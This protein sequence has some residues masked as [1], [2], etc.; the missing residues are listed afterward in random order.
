MPGAR[1]ALAGAVRAADDQEATAPYNELVAGSTGSTP[2]FQAEYVYPEALPERSRHRWQVG[3]H[4]FRADF[5]SANLADIR[6]T[7]YP[8][9]YQAWI[10]RDCQ[11]TPVE[12]PHRTWF[13]F[14]VAGVKKGE[15]VTITMM[16]MN[17][18][19]K[20][21]AQD[22]R[23]VYR[24]HPS[25]QIWQRLRTRVVA[26]LVGEDLTVQLSHCFE[27]CEETFFAFATPWSCSDNQALLDRLEGR[28]ASTSG[29]IGQAQPIYKKR[30]LLQRSL[31]GRPIDL[32]TITDNQG[33]STH[34]A[35][36]APADVAGLFPEAESEGDCRTFPGRQVFFISARVHPGETPASHMLNGMLEF[37]L[38][39]HDPRAIALR[40]LYVFKIVPMLNP[41]GVARG[42]TR[43]DSRGQNL[44]RCYR[45]P[46]Q[47]EQPGIWAV[48]QLLSWYASHGQLAFYMDLHAHA[49]KRGCF[50]YGN[51]MEGAAAVEALTFVKLA[52]LNCPHFDFGACNFTEQN[53]SSRDKQGESKDGTGRVALFRETSLTHL[54]TVEAN[55]NSSRLQNSV[56]A[57]T[58]SGKEQV[59]PPSKLRQSAFYSMDSFWGMGRALLVAALDLSGTNSCSRLANTMFQDTD[60]V[61]SWV[62][63][64]VKEMVGRKH[65]AV[66][67]LSQTTSEGISELPNGMVTRMAALR[68]AAT[69][70]QGRWR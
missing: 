54:Y 35:P 24:A 28:L 67:A 69:C 33:A 2:S 22:F 37:L 39:P 19:A 14:S 30:Q 36:A 48:K 55:Y 31:D 53:M 12:T 47:A 5:D 51:A 52:A 58:T 63:S 3:E 41:D 32:L 11:G 7:A 21:Y 64:C 38:R 56:A 49:N 44:N 25:M 8:N 29:H 65:A 43:C 40:R 62:R 17:K 34:P 15:P 4:S 27:S 61:A 60:G 10:C 45:A 18:Q 57:A 9:E 59:S 42:Y 26:K 20:L 46:S 50:A 1:R 13:H 16:N 6:A 68:L 23:P 66:P 70:P